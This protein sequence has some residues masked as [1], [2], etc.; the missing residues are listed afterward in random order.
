MGVTSIARKEA[1]LLQL[2]GP[3]VQEIYETLRP[4]NES[5]GSTLNPP[6]NIFLFFRTWQNKKQEMPAKGAISKFLVVN[7]KKWHKRKFFFRMPSKQN[8]I[9]TQCTKMEHSQSGCCTRAKIPSKNEPH[10]SRALTEEQ[11]QDTEARSATAY[12]D[13]YDYYYHP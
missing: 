13:D 4:A 7:V 9:S 10:A 12:L 1:T 5:Y 8:Q 2:I 3:E 11:T 6:V